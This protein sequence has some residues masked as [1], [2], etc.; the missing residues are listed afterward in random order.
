MKEMNDFDEILNYSIIRL[1][2]TSDVKVLTVIE[3]LAIIAGMFLVMYF[4][5]KSNL[6]IKAFRPW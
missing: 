5:K 2:K 3:L 4:I 6:Q 1:T